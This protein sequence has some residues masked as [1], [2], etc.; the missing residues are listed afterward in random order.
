MEEMA[1]NVAG[2]LVTSTYHEPARDNTGMPLLVTLHGGTYTSRYFEVA[3]GPLGSFTDLAAR[4]GFAVL[5]VNRPGYGGSSALP[6][7]DCTFQRQAEALDEAISLRVR[8]L[9]PRSVVLIGHSVGGMVS[10]EIAAR[11]P[12]W[13]LA[14]VSATGMCS[15]VVPGDAIDD[16]AAPEPVG[17]VDLPIEVR[18]AT[19][20]GPPGTYTEAARQ[21]AREAYAPAPARELT[22][23]PLWAAGRLA[24]V[25]ALIGVPVQNFLAEH[26]RFWDTSQEAL[27]LFP[28]LFTGGADVTATLFRGVGH[29]IDHHV[30]G[31]ALH[32]QQL[33]FSC[34]V[35]VMPRVRAPH[36]PQAWTSARPS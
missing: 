18:E 9:A 19:M 14:G 15:R 6:D 8:E 21:A 31:P 30:L 33:A 10:L 16:M 34:A 11:R 20:F 2:L 35:T 3:G 23:A 24:G 22:E 13:P 1:D 32:F 28:T 7:A 29:S 36:G 25:A 17:L 27:A 26:D 4:N 12:T 5:N